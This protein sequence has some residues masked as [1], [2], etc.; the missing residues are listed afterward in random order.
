VSGTIVGVVVA[1]ESGEVLPHSIVVVPSLD[2][3]RFSSDSGTFVLRD[4]P[5]GSHLVQIRRLGYAP[6]EVTVAVRA[7]ARD[8]VRI[9][10][11]RVAVKLAPVQVRADP[12]CTTPGLSAIKDSALSTVLTQLRMNG[13]QYRLLTEAYPFVYGHERMFVRALKSGETRTDVVDTVLIQSKNAWRYRPGHILTREGNRRRGTLFFNLPT[14]ADFADPLFLD[15]HCFSDGGIDRVDDRELIRIEVVASSRI[16]NPDVNGSMFLD[17]RTFQIRRSVLRLSRNPKVNGMTGL[18][19]TTLFQEALESVPI[20]T[21]VYSVQTFDE[22]DRRRDFVALY[23]HHRMV[24]FTFLGA[25]PGDD[26]RP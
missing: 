9:E 26:A 21:Q 25:R 22:R 16:K 24:T 19:V 4:V 8:S 12:P 7:G 14:L 23:E 5:A 20:I 6:T 2:V 3:R 17:P 15:N 18:E 11:T 13:E 1:R 10:L